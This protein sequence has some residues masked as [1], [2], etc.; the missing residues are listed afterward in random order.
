MDSVYRVVQ[1]KSEQELNRFTKL[2]DA[3]VLWVKDPGE[4]RVEEVAVG[5]NNVITRVPPSECCSTLRKWL[6]GNKFLSKDERADMAVLIE[7]ACGFS[8]Q[9]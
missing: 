8:K 5:T 3:C 4:R 7:E 6:P 2:A 1:V 9:G